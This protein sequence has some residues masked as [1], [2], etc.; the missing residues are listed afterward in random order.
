MPS[1]IRRKVQRSLVGCAS[2]LV[3][4][5]VVFGAR[6]L[7]GAQ[8]PPPLP[9]FDGEYE[10]YRLPPVTDLPLSPPPTIE[11]ATVE[12]E[13]VPTP[14]PELDQALIVEETI[15]PPPKIWE[16]SAEVGLNGSTGN[17]EILTMRFGAHA[18]R[19]A[20]DKTLTL[21]LNYSRG[22]NSGVIT[23]NRGFFNARHDWA[24]QD[25]PWTPFVK[26]VLEYDQFRAFDVRVVANAGLGYQFLK[27]EA[28]TLIGRLG[29][30][31]SQEIGGP[32]DDIV[33]EGLAGLEFCHKLSESQSINASTE[34]FP[35]IGDIRDF[36]AVNK[37]EWEMLV[38]PKWNTSLKLAANHRY[39][40][41]PHGR[42][43]NDLDYTLLVMWKY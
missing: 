35:D 4:I 25:S 19:C 9:A 27:N 34:Y 21:D 17:S 22:S 10:I 11:Q 38:D 14:D 13:I 6:S 8:T 29:S 33:P 31:F 23:E 1:T 20:N 30:G 36:R 41:T 43:K 12:V 24:F 37:A 7:A 32:D 26:G 28:T 16:A 18:K 3:W 2:L 40:S 15:E 39:D 5:G 42:K